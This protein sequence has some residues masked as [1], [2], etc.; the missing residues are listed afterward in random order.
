MVVCTVRF[1][2]LSVLL[3]N[4]QSYLFHSNS[5]ENNDQQYIR[6]LDT[7]KPVSGVLYYTEYYYADSQCTQLYFFQSM[8]INQCY[9][10]S[11]AQ[12]INT[13][14]NDYVMNTVL[15]L[16]T[17]KGFLLT[18]TYYNDVQCSVT[19]NGNPPQVNFNTP[20]QCQ[21]VNSGVVSG[22]G[23]LFIVAS[24]SSSPPSANGGG[25]TIKGYGLVGCSGNP[26]EI[27]YYVGN[28]AGTLN[29]GAST[30]LGIFQG[31]CGM[32]SIGLQIYPPTY[33]VSSAKCSAGTSLAK[34]SYP[35]ACTEKG[36]IGQ[37]MAYYGIANCAGAFLFV[38]I[39][40]V[41]HKQT[42]KQT[43]THP[44]TTPYQ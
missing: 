20:T 26:Q 44:M 29:S 42:N 36:F 9:Y 30:C 11:N 41:V 15:S 27:S 4:I 5:H 37:G 16:G 6:K 13:A 39:F 25:I 7:A 32:N 43:I 31:L 2:S 23:N 24:T 38:C 28:A 10:S 21:A 18:Q 3:L 34:L 35:I 1:L 17:N 19:D 22:L 8:V 33:P 40:D 12:S 14:A